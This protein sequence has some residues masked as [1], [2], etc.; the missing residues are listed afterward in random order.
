[1]SYLILKEMVKTFWDWAGEEYREDDMATAERI[2]GEVLGGVRGGVG[3][4]GKVEKQG[5]DK[6]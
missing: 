1:M 2:D 4:T 6:A 5:F 3:T